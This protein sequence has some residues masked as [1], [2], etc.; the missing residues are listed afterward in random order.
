MDA[1][2][3]RLRKMFGFLLHSFTVDP[4][5][6]KRIWCIRWCNRWLRDLTFL[7]PSC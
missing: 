5:F 6:F 2:H 4:T 3:G 1:F 7:A